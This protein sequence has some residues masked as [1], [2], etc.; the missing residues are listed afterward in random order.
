MLIANGDCLSIENKNNPK[1][2][3]EEKNLLLQFKQNLWGMWYGNQKQG[4]HL[5]MLK[6]RKTSVW[7]QPWFPLHDKW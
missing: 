5:K 4:S 7:N 6:Q 2:L 1:L 3:V